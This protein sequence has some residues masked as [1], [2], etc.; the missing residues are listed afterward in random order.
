MIR[1]QSS[2]ASSRIPQKK[3]LPRPPP[4]LD[5]P[6]EEEDVSLGDGDMRVVLTPEKCGVKSFGNSNLCEFLV[7]SGDFRWIWWGYV[8]QTEKIFRIDN[9]DD[10]E[11]QKYEHVSPGR[12][13]WFLSYRFQVF[14]L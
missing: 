11:S 5:D 10:Y 13:R 14:I 4:T 9:Y 12:Y 6:V 2:E 3:Q 8:G 1:P 7:I